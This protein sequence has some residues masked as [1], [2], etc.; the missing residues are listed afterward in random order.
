MAKRQPRS[1]QEQELLEKAARY[2]PGGT[3][4]NLNLP[5]ERSI[6]IKA[7]Q[8]ARVYDTTGNE[9]VDYLLGSG[10]MILGHA[11][12]AVTEAVREAVGKGSTFYAINEPIIHLAEELVRAVPCAEKVRF[13]TSGTDANF[14]CLRLAR[15]FRKRDKVLKFEGGYHGSSDYAMMSAPPSQPI[16]Y[17]SPAP[18]AAGI[19]KAVAET[20]L[21]APF[22]DLETTSAII[23]KHHDELAGV[24][25]E[26]FQ[27]VLPPRPGFL[28]GLRDVTAQYEIPLIFDEVVTGFRFAY[29]GAQEFYGVVPDLAALGKIMGGGYPLAAVVGREELMRYYDPD[30]HGTPEFVPQIGTL[31]GNPVSAV[32]GLATLRELRKPGAYERLYATGNQLM[33]GLASLLQQAEIPAQ[34]IGVGPLFDVYFTDQEEVWDY[35]DT[36]KA[37]GTRLREFHGLLLEHGVFKSLQKFYLSLAH[38]QEDVDWTMEAFAAAIDQMRD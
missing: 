14:Q 3:L 10:P 26:P 16:P 28:Q 17:P 4:G 31:S 20:V 6:V 19:P 9:Y 18:S 27:R 11:H 29:G 36:L 35:R 13:T 12:P 23:E 21:V 15:T 37:D 32:A 22:N 1:P 33:K 2:I 8:G 7:G 25:L 30:L 5:Q 34:V 38:T 24:I